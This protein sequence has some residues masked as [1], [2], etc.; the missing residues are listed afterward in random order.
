MSA[1]AGFD[2]LVM[3]LAFALLY[4]VHQNAGDALD[5]QAPKPP[6]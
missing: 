4:A 1:K 2:F 5:P 3:A 6:P